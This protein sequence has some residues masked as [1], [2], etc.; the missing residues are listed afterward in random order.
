MMP[1][2]DVNANKDRFLCTVCSVRGC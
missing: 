1:N 2:C